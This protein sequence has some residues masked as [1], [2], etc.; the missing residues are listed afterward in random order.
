MALHV[1]DLA[2]FLEVLEA[3]EAYDTEE[4]LSISLLAGCYYLNGII[5]V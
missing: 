1:L 4:I 3:L 2:E 5:A